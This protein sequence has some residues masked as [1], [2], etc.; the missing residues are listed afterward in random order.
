MHVHVVCAFLCM[1]VFNAM[2]I[3]V[4]MM[5]ACTFMSL[6]TINIYTQRRVHV[7]ISTCYMHV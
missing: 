6:C 2:C 5:P 1:N 3:Q 7:C 4:H